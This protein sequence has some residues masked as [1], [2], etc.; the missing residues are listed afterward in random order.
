MNWP[1]SA[2]GKTS[3]SGAGVWCL[4]PEPIKS[5]TRCQH[6]ATACNLD[7]WALAQAAKMGTAHS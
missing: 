2:S 1:D 6:L 4:N 7:V 3:A 5:L